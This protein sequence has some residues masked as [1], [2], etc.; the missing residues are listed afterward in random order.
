MATPS[1]AIV[2]G[3]DSDWTTMEKCAAQLDAFGLGYSVQVISAHRTPEAAHEFAANARQ[4]G[5]KVIIAAAGMS[6]ALAGVMASLTTLPVIG[7]PMAGGAMDGLDALLSTAMMPP[8]VP[9]AS[10]GLGAAKNAA[11]LAAQILAIS[12]VALADTLV[13][14]KKQMAAEVE[15]KN[16]ALQAKVKSHA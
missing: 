2:M 13:A 4:R 5:V 10:V 7:V 6:A 9:V 12:D 15:A 3:S 11:I 16:A 8:G 14:F 1:I